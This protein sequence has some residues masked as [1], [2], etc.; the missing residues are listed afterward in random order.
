MKKLLFIIC[1]SLFSITSFSQDT[2]RLSEQSKAKIKKI[3]KETLNTI[4]FVEIGLEKNRIKLS[5]NNVDIYNPNISTIK[6][7]YSNNRLTS[8]QISKIENIICYKC[9][10]N[11]WLNQKQT[12]KE[13][14]SENDQAYNEKYSHLQKI[15]DKINNL[16]TITARIFSDSIAYSAKTPFEFFKLKKYKKHNDKYIRNFIYYYI[17]TNLTVEEDKENREF[18]CDKCMKVYFNVYYDGANSDLEIEGIQKLKF[19]QVYGSFLDLFPTWKR[20]FLPTVNKDKV[21]D[22]FK[23]RD[24]KNRKLGINVR[25]S[26]QNGIWQIYNWSF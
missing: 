1:L 18:S 2:N 10:E 14:T 11:E 8:N 7:A 19:Q 20:E 5:D 26:K 6:Q 17:P 12:L 15:K 25:I 13:V 22:D 9:Y 4:L 21:L 3:S 16:D 24:V 23:F